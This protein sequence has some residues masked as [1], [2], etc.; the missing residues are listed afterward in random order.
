[1]NVSLE[2]AFWLMVMICGCAMFACLAGWAWALLRV[3][4]DVRAVIAE[5]RAGNGWNLPKTE[6]LCLKQS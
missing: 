3:L 1:M 5:H 2:I 6:G 4:R